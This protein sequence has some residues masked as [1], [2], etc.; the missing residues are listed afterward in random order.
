MLQNTAV[1]VKSTVRAAVVTGWVGF[2]KLLV[3]T[4]DP[5]A[6]QPLDPG[7]RYCSVYMTPAA[8]FFLGDPSFVTICGINLLAAV[9]GAPYTYR[10]E[11]IAFGFAE[12]APRADDCLAALPPTAQ[13]DRARSGASGFRFGVAERKSLSTLQNWPERRAREQVQ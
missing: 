11:A 4:V 12:D 2:N 5:F 10:G 9:F 8:Y 1:A 13:R 6:P 3:R 7:V